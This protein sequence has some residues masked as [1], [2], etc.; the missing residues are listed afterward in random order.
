MLCIDFI[1]LIYMHFDRIGNDE[2]STAFTELINN[3]TVRTKLEGDDFVAI[4][5]QSD[6]EA[7]MQ[8]A[9]I[10]KVSHETIK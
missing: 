5:V 8:F 3:D 4:R 7:Y 2:M 10:C 1:Y 6:S 9:A